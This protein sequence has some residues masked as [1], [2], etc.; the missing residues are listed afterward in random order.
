MAILV[1]TYLKDSKQIKLHG[2]M[3][4]SLFPILKLFLPAFVD[5]ED[6]GVKP[7]TSNVQ[8]Q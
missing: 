4:L 5:L 3:L 7:A 1:A 8:R 2:K 6:I